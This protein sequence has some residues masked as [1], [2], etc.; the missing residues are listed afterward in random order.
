[1]LFTEA[2]CLP[3]TR[4]LLMSFVLIHCI[5]SISF[6]APMKFYVYSVLIQEIKELIM[7][8]NVT[9]CHILR[10]GNRCADFMTKLEASSNIEFLM[11]L[12]PMIC[13]IFARLMRLEPSFLEI[14][15]FFFLVLFFLLFLFFISLQ[16]YYIITIITSQPW[17]WKHVVAVFG[18]RDPN[19]YGQ[20]HCHTLTKV[21][22]SFTAYSEC[23]DDIFQVP[24][25]TLS[26]TFTHGQALKLFIYQ[27]PSSTSS[28]LELICKKLAIV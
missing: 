1:M 25:L 20:W 7:Q 17:S 22:E 21:G 13:D 14:S 6:K 9:V 12:L 26:L 2:F 10:E 11:I 15:C 16:N 19:L 8:L 23:S 4:I 24:I 5:A 28:G 18:S 3:K 27:F